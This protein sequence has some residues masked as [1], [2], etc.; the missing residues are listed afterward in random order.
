MMA[1][2][3]AGAGLIVTALTAV[4]W[5]GLHMQ[6]VWRYGPGRRAAMTAAATVVRPLAIEPSRQA[7]GHAYE[8]RHGDRSKHQR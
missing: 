8:Q 1:W 4:R 7:Y 6:L 3:E 2:L 5:L